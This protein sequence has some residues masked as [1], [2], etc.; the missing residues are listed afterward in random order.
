MKNKASYKAVAFKDSLL[1][2]I[3]TPT[4]LAAK[5]AALI[6]FL[7]IVSIA[8]AVV[9]A[10]KLGRVRL[11]IGGFIGCA[12]GLLIP[13]FSIDFQ[14]STRIAL[15]FAGFMMFNFMDE[16]RTERADLSAGG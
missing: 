5:G 2:G 11:Q 6:T 15:I 9:L 13:S 7:L 16:Y 3:F 10:D 1:H 4:I 12:L 14:G 8:F